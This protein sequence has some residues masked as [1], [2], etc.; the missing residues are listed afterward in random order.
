[1]RTRCSVDNSLSS[2]QRISMSP[3][4]QVTT[5]GSGSTSVQA[6]SAELFAGTKLQSALAG[7]LMQKRKAV[8]IGV[9]AGAPAGEIRGLGIHHR[10]IVQKPQRALILA[11]QRIVALGEEIGRESRA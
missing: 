8:E 1:M 4:L 3:I 7:A 9:G 5:P 2:L 10:Q 6:I 11:R